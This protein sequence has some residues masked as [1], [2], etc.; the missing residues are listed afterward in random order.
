MC[1]CGVL[2][3]EPFLY[4][5]RCPPCSDWAPSVSL[6]WRH[7]LCVCN[8]LRVP[9]PGDGWSARGGGCRPAVPRLEAPPGQ[10]QPGG[11]PELLPLD[12]EPVLL[13]VCAAA[14]PLE[15]RGGNPSSTV[16]VGQHTINTDGIQQEQNRI[17]CRPIIFNAY[18]AN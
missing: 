18:A 7:L 9:G 3:A 13:G 5:S 12:M 11:H 6:R 15:S 4:M 14:L 10:V 8:E 2:T 16:L 17:F 1:W